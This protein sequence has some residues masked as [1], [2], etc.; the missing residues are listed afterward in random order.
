MGGGPGPG[1]A[2]APTPTVGNAQPS[3][4]EARTDEQAGPRPDSD[5]APPVDDGETGPPPA[6]A[7]DNEWVILTEGVTW[8]A[9]PEVIDALDIVITEPS[10]GGDDY[11]VEVRPTGSVP[12]GEPVVFELAIEPGGR[13][14]VSGDAGWRCTERHPVLR[15]ER[16]D[17]LA[18]DGPLVVRITPAEA[19]PLSGW[20][21]VGLAA[22]AV[23]AMAG[24]ALVAVRR[25][26]SDDEDAQPDRRA[27]P[28]T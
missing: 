22:G 4:A 3:P 11:L 16:V 19:G 24:F 5:A 21:G 18:A 10:G 1:S 6:L 17:D 13:F 12:A 28:V 27:S 9:A 23:I 8:T 26:S 7:F 20:P 2:T 14:E 15:C 25:R